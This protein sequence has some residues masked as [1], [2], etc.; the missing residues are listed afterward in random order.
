MALCLSDSL[1]IDDIQQ[2]SL[3]AVSQSCGTV[4]REDEANKKNYSH[5]FLLLKAN[6][7]WP[8]KSIN[9]RQFGHTG[10][11]RKRPWVTDARTDGQSSLM[12]EFTWIFFSSLKVPKKNGNTLRLI[13]VVRS[14]R[15]CWLRSHKNMTCRWRKQ[16]W[17]RKIN[18]VRS[19]FPT[20]SL[21]YS[22]KSVQEEEE[23]A[24]ELCD[25]GDERNFYKFL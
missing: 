25:P 14:D 17:R 10:T 24:L 13:I 22:H 9:Y 5:N 1:F 15:K 3:E 2:N 23:E 18:S 4:D 6:K 8:K 20:A 21:K 12:N 11:L 7:S 19:F 16:M